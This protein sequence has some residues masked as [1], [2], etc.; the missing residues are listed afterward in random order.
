MR[1]PI[2]A[3]GAVLV[4]NGHVGLVHRPR[5]DDWTLPK[6]KADDDEHLT[7]T[8][9]RE[10]FEETGTRAR[11][12]PPLTP[13]RYFVGDSL[14][15]VAWWKGEILAEGRRTAPADEI[16]AVVWLPADRA[17]ARLTY[18]DERAVLA[19]ALAL[20]PTT[21]LLLVRHAKSVKRKHWS[22]ADRDRP[23][24][25]AA[26]AQ[27]PCL[28]QVLGAY[29]VTELVTSPAARCVATIAPYARRAGLRWTEAEALTETEGTTHPAAL[30]EVVTTAAAA[31]GASGRPTAICLH[32]PN[33]PAM[34]DAL[35]LPARPLAP[36]AVIVAHVDRD[37]YVVATEWHDS[38]RV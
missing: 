23:L 2:W 7:R 14:K 28:E 1:V 3:A 12:G 13:L 34:L 20:P 26:D 6:G 32:R 15:L 21:P 11:L 4:K 5:Y 19:E 33:L 38:A 31:A 30:Q 16:D 29:G 17:A 25:A 27:L 35:G 8:A 36:A 9:V 18:A 24:D 22:G 37:G 10:V